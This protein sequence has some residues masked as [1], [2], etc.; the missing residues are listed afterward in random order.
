MA[1]LTAALYGRADRYE[2]DGRAWLANPGLV[3]DAAGLPA[4]WE[5]EGPPG[6]VEAVTGGV[7]LTNRDPDG[8]VGLRQVIRRERGE[9]AVFDLSAVVSGEGIAGGRPGWRPGRVTVAPD[10]G[11]DAEPVRGDHVELMNVRGTRAPRA[12]QHRFRF[13]DRTEAVELAFRLRTATGALVVRDLS[14][15]GMVERPGFRAAATGLRAAWA[16]LFAG[17]LWLAW[18]GLARPVDRLLVGA[19]ATGAAT[20]LLLPV[21]LRQA[22]TEEVSRRLLGGVV[23]SGTAA[24]LGHVGL[25]LA[26]GWLARRLR[27][28]DT[29]PRLLPAMVLLAG[30]GELAQYLAD[31]RHPSLEDWGCNAL[32]AT[33]GLI[34]GRS[35]TRGKPDAGGP[36]GQSAE[37]EPASS[38]RSPP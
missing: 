16:A 36:A 8:F 26:I 1:A 24:Q 18:T 38:A 10:P 5:V 34:L 29:L 35:W 30:V 14:V 31:A 6:S 37:A 11:P 19:L 32:G 17:W 21:D 4:G 2:P 22:L 23:G 9:A 25:F 12:Y 13:G 28:G 7:R 3:P 27:P 33:L 15:T 20:L